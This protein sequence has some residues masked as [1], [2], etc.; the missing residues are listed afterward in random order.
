VLKRRLAT[1]WVELRGLDGQLVR[2]ICHVVSVVVTVIVFLEGGRQF[3]IPL[4]TLVA[5]AGMGGLAV[6]L[7]AQDTLK[8]VFRSIMV[9]LDHSVDEHC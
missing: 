6:A 8:S 5:G 9:T 4:T 1:P 2:L 7:A 3:G